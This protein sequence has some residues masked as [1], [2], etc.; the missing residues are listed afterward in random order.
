M[1][2]SLTDPSLQATSFGGSVGKPDGTDILF[3]ASD[4]V[5]KLNHEI[6]S[7][8]AAT[9]QLAAWVNLPALSGTA[10]TVIYV[11]FGNAAASDQQNKAG[12]W[13]SNFAGVW[14]MSDNAASTTV[15][16]S[17]QNSGT[18]TAHASTNSRTATGQIGGALIFD[19]V[20]DYVTAPKATAID[21]PNNTPVTT[22]A[23]VNVSAFT[24]PSQVL[25]YI[26]GKGYNNGAE[27]YFLRIQNDSSG[28]SL[29]AGMVNSSTFAASWPISS[30]N[31]GEWHH[32]VSSWD[33]SGWNIFFD[34][35]LKAQFATGNGPLK[36]GLPLTMG[37]ESIGGVI[38]GLLACSL[39]EV[40]ISTT[41]R[42]SSWIATEYNN[43]RYP[44]KFYTVGATQ[45]H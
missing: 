13:D 3:T 17:T 23:W 18:A 28:L 10:D 27:A 34:G 38:A 44:T 12:V 40:R 30:W 45:T 21:I 36:L 29:K 22:E 8:N 31:P 26:L 43:Q 33:G 24:S 19:G 20:S 2:F 15:A 7:Y 42:S 25:G 37:G 39:D 11:Y 5:T 41:A 4:G 14:H 1:L 16:D 6:E 32:V 9:G 35:V